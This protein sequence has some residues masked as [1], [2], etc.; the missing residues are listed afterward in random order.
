MNGIEQFRL[1]D[2]VQ[3][4][5]SDFPA[6]VKLPAAD[7]EQLDK[8]RKEHNP[9]D[10]EPDDPMRHEPRLTANWP[11]IIEEAGRLLKTTSKDLTLAARLTEAW[12]K[13]HGILGT[14]AGF[15]LLRRLCAEAWDRLHPAPE[16]AE[17]DDV[18]TRLRDFRWLDDP[19][20]KGMKGARFPFTVRAVPL[21]RHGSTVVSADTCRPRSGKPPVVENEQLRAV[22]NALSQE[23]CEQTL[24]NIAASLTELEG[25]LA[26]LNDNV[27]ADLVRLGL[28][29]G[30]AEKRKNEYLPGFTETR[31]AL[32]ECKMIAEQMLRQRAAAG[33]DNLPVPLDANGTAVVATRLSMGNGFSREQIYQQL[34][35][36]AD[37][38]EQVEPHSPVPFLIRRAVELR[39]LKFPKLVEILTRD[40]R[41]L[42]FMKAEIDVEASAGV[43]EAQGG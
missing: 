10:Y 37:A 4:I 43:S 28:A 38:L 39:S 17:P 9:E 26:A 41:V 31:K 18:D 34:R 19:E 5:S 14:R 36:A 29:E 1:D 27:K 11:G 33:G 6:G 23:E 12:T 24:G 8:L 21:A 35:M 30:E 16:L 15:A 3:P 2:L 25:L 20:S 7:R 42:D 40:A 32:E 22:A 13:Q